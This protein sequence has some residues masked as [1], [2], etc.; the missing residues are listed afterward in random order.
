MY[1]TEYLEKEESNFIKLAHTTN[2][3]YAIIDLHK[4]ASLQELVI[5]NVPII[6]DLSPLKYENTY[7]SS[8]LFPFA[9]RIKDGTYVYKGTTYQFKINLKEENNALHGLVYDK[10]FKI[11][12][13]TASEH[14]ASVTLEYDETDISQGFPYTYTIILTYTLTA[15]GID[16]ST[17]V[18][19]TDSNAFPFTLGWHPYF[20]SKNLYESSLKFDSHQKLILNER[21]I[22]TG[23][24]PYD[25]KKVFKV[26]DKNL[27]DCFILNSNTVTFETPGYDLEMT[28]SS[29]TTFLQVYTP[30]K[31]NTIAIEPTTGVSDSFNN[32]IGLQ[33]LE[34]EHT[35]TI[36]W[37]IKCFFN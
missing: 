13:E 11:I 36:D 2:N 34:P 9:N 20:I 16:L 23:I 1:K 12:E 17:S 24:E 35:Y 21:M 31:A 37:K 10:A 5:N 15:N 7:A 22:T 28:T 3:N 26:E 33:V 25:G 29:N 32:K 30:P 18:K 6:E 8:V 27:D 4:G 14:A 19:N